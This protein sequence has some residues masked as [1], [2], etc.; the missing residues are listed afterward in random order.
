MSADLRKLLFEVSEA[1]VTDE[2]AAL[3]FL[4]VE[5]VPRRK[6]EA[7]QDPKA[8]FEVLQQKDM[9]GVG[10]LSFLKELL[11]CIDR[12]DLLSA[13][14][15]SSREQMDR[16]LQLP[17]RAQVSAYRQLL[18]RLAEDLAPE[19]VL[20][21]KFLLQM[22]LP[23]TKLQ[24]N[25]SML[26]V[27]LEMEM[28]GII[29]EDNLTML[30][31]ILQRFRPDLKKKI[32]AYEEKKRENYSREEV[33]YS[34]PASVHPEERGGEQGAAHWVRNTSRSP[35]KYFS[36]SWERE[37]KFITLSRWNRRILALYVGLGKNPIFQTRPGLLC[38]DLVV[39]NLCGDLAVSNLL[40]K[41]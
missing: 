34:V 27:F 39:S 38:G 3:K 17:G 1:L 7:I 18:Y 35:L 11:Y 28:N 23:K 14:L 41:K 33:R 25:A 36:I 2:L 6:L 5:H 40:S 31:D 20:N 8:F 12:M 10:N 37:H 9:I 32:D 15:G 16:E 22:R 29:K 19:D 24:E 13:Q 21:M 4:S 26:Q 30:K